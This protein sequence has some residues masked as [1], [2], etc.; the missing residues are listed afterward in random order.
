MVN[1]LVNRCEFFRSLHVPGRPV[2]LPNAWDAASAK[3]VAAAGFRAV[4][5]TSGGVAQTLGH[6]DHEEAPVDEMLAAASRMIRSVEVPVT[7]DFEAGYA[8]EPEELVAR[9][10][11]IG[12]VGANLEDSNH[13]S[14]RLRNISVQAGFLSAIRAA[15][16]HAGYPLVLNARIDVFLHHRDTPQGQLVDV[17]IERARAYFE[18]GV[19][20]V[21]PIFLADVAARRAV[22]A[23]A[24]GPVNL[25]AQDLPLRELAADGVAR[26]SYGTTLHRRTMG[27]FVEQLERISP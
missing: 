3:A 9:L 24:G 22:I 10:Q 20:C 25:L 27:A 4:A 17:C 26:V 18:A 16:S 15:A 2:V 1:A 8:L 12:A 14:H 23:G 7:V 13:G 5:T 6:N 11:E 19:D 21:Y